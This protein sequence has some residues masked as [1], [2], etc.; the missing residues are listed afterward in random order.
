MSL[1]GLVHTLIA[2]KPPKKK[3]KTLESHQGAMK[4]DATKKEASWKLCLTTELLL[5]FNYTE[6]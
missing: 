2:V 5:F 6:L 1:S 3:K 4:I